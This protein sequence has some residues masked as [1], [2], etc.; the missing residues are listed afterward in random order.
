MVITSQLKWHSSALPW[1][2]VKTQEML[3]PCGGAG[4]PGAAFISLC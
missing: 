4:S 1:L 2:D 3:F